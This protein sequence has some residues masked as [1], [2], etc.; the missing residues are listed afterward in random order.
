[1]GRP[2]LGKT[3]MSGAERTRRY[4]AKFRHSEPV[5][6][7]TRAADADRLITETKLHIALAQANEQIAALQKGLAQAKARI[8]ELEAKRKRDG[9]RL[10]RSARQDSSFS[11]VGKLRG[12][13]AKLRSDIFKL[14]AAL[15]EEPD[16][17]KLR[18]KV[19]DQRVEMMG[20]RTELKRLAKERDK[21]QH[22]VPEVR[23]LRSVARFDQR[24]AFT[25]I[26]KA[27]HEDRL[28]TCSKAELNEANKYFL[29]LKPLFRLLGM[30]QEP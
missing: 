13:I 18:K 7:P 29:E 2:P 5:T 8:A 11:E 26:A 6:K 4:R 3:A 28:Q 17:S 14:K 9:R 21:L 25:V 16:A 30:L 24:K 27:L 19:I 10:V 15:A 22:M 23:K 20:L 1:V 12:E